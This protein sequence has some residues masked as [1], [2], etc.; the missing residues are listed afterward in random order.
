MGAQS[1]FDLAW[2]VADIVMGAMA[3]VNIISIVLLGK[4][5]LRAL[6]DY[7][8]QRKQHKDPVFVASNIP[9]LPPTQCW[10]ETA[11]ELAE[12]DR[13][14]RVGEEEAE[15]GETAQTATSSGAAPRAALV[16][17]ASPPCYRHRR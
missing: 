9:G 2:N 4:W 5:A 12:H 17:G 16:R 8:A 11:E 15:A 7:T 3:F 6:D 14:L 13:A 10:H 1:S